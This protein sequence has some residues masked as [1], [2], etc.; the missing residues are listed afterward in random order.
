MSQAL[1]AIKNSLQNSNI[2]NKSQETVNFMPFSVKKVKQFSGYL[3]L[4]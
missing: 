4:Q 1:L 3:P 2:F